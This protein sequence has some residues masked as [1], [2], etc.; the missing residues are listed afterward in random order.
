MEGVI[1]VCIHRKWMTRFLSLCLITS[2]YAHYIR[3]NASHFKVKI[4]LVKF[5]HV[6][7]KASKLHAATK[8]TGS[9]TK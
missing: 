9:H 6:S 2:L 4:S 5:L 3:Y 7:A 1:P 8:S